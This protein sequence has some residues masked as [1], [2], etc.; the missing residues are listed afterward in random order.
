M[1]AALRLLQHRTN[2]AQTAK[3]TTVNALN[4][5]SVDPDLGVWALALMP[6]KDLPTSVPT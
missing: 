5:P 4:R 3:N 6:A 1:A 2:A